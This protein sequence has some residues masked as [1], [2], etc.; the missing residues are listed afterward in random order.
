MYL[1]TIFDRYGAI[2]HQ[3]Q[4]TDEGKAIMWMIRHCTMSVVDSLGL[5]LKEPVE[6]ELKQKRGAT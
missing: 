1:V 4:F 5:K 3:Q 2:M 6:W